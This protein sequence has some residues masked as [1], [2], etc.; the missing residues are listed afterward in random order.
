MFHQ[1]DLVHVPENV[2]LYSY[3]AD[4]QIVWPTDTSKKPHLAIFL[5]YC[6]MKYASVVTES[7][8][9]WIVEKSDIFF[10]ESQNAH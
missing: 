5:E 10:K 8:D 6:D 9:R 4:R 2:T 3:V 1:G 7:G